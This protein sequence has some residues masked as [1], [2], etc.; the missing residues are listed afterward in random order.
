MKTPCGAGGGG[1][2]GEGSSGFGG[3]DHAS[4]CQREERTPPA[5]KPP[6]LGATEEEETTPR[7]VWL[8]SLPILPPPS[9]PLAPSRHPFSSASIR[10]SADA[11]MP[12]RQ[13]GWL[14]SSSESSDAARSGVP[15]ARGGV[16]ADWVRRAESPLAGPPAPEQPLAP[17]APVLSALPQPALPQPPASLSVSAWCRGMRG[18]G[19]IS[20]SRCPLPISSSWVSP[21]VELLSELLGPGTAPTTEPSILRHMGCA[22]H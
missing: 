7:L 12:D 11:P 5:G 9:P 16:A 20:G 1:G 19:T 8:P 21:V 10:F 6:G 18:T 13:N 14:R 17:L 22:R 4:A 15:R 3:G 2:G